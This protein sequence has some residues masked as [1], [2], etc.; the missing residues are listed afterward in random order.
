MNLF[1]FDAFTLWTAGA[2]AFGAAGALTLEHGWGWVLATVKAYIAKEKAKA[3]AAVA[4]LDS[5]K[6]T[7]EAHLGP[8]TGALTALQQDVAAIKTKVGI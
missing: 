2:V 5:I 3:S 1:Q 4:N 7:I 8:V 6:A